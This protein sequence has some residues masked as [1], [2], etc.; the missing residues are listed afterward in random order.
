MPPTTLID[1]LTF[2]LPA[3]L[4]NPV[5]LILPTLNPTFVIFAKLSLTLINASRRLSPVP[6]FGTEPTFI[7][8]ND[9]VSV[10]FNSIQ[11]YSCI[12][13]WIDIK[14][15]DKRYFNYFR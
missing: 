5:T 9:E 2:R 14:K 6:S 7:D 15:T 11:E 8:W 13:T 1:P 10:I 3:T 4:A 12:Y